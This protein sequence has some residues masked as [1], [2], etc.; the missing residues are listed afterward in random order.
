M[1]CVTHLSPEKRRENW[2][3]GVERG[4]KGGENQFHYTL[5]T[6]Y[7]SGRHL[8]TDPLLANSAALALAASV[9]V[10]ATLVCARRDVNATFVH[11]SSRSSFVSLSSIITH[12]CIVPPCSFQTLSLLSTRH[13]RPAAIRPL[14]HE[15]HKQI[16]LTG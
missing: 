9:C 1:P 12:I 14:Y 13:F 15:Q 7:S 11:V 5:I 8:C 16:Q 10:R 3:W 6:T 2:G 4:G